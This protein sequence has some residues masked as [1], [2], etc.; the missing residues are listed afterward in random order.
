M[1]PENCRARKLRCQKTDIDDPTCVNCSIRCLNCIVKERMRVDAARPA[2]VPLDMQRSLPEYES[3][4]QKH[5][6]Q[7][8]NF[9]EKHAEPMTTYINPIIMQPT[10]LHG[11]TAGP[12]SHDIG[13]LSHVDILPISSSPPGSSNSHC[14]PPTKHLDEPSHLAEL[15]RLYGGN[16]IDKWASQHY[17]ELSE[18]VFSLDSSWQ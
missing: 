9:R 17:G 3:N 18:F 11:G 6:Y 10:I 1:C 13:F 12:Q 16:G 5:K 4:G 2:T 14:D 7:A 15:S 8:G